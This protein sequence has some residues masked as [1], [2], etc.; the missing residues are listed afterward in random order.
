MRPGQGNPATGGV[1]AL[2]TAGIKHHQAGQLRE[3]EAAYRQVLAAA[4]RQFDATHLLGVV[5]LQSGRL[6]DASRLITDALTLNPASAPAL[7]NLGN[8]FLRQERLDDALDSFRRAVKLQPGF[9]DAH[10]NLGNLLRRRGELNDAAVHLK[11][12][13]AID[14]RSIQAQS[15]FG[16][17]LL[18]LGDGAGAVRAFEA[19]VKIRPDQAGTHADLGAALISAG[20]FPRAIDVL[21]RA[22]KLDPTSPEATTRRGMALA[23][24][25]RF[26][27]AL[28]C[29][30]QIAAQ[31]PESGAAHFNLGALLREMGAYERAIALLRR[32]LKLA[33]DLA[34][35][36]LVLAQTLRDAGHHAEAREQA[37]R[38]RHMS[39]RSA[40]MLILE[41]ALCLDH[42]DHSGAETAFREA[43]VVDPQ[44]ADGHYQMGNVLMFRGRAAE[45]L[46]SYK[47]AKALDP[48][49]VHARWAI[50]MAQIT[51]VPADAEEAACSRAAFSRELQALDNW[52]DERRTADGYK[53][54]GSTQ[55]FYIAY[56]AQD[57][58][59]LLARYGA[60]CAKLMKRWQANH[61]VVKPRRPRAAIAP[62][63]V[64]IAS[65]HLN[66]HSVWHAIVKGWVTNL[67]RRRFEIFL[68]NLDG[69]NDSET[70][71]AMQWARHTE[72]RRRG[73]AQWSQCIADSDL[74]VLIYPAI[75]MDTKTVQLAAQRLAP[76]QGTTWGHPDTSGLPT[77]DFYLSAEGL[78]PAGA[79]AHYTERLVLLPHFGVTYDPA[80]VAAALPDL[81][82]LGLPTDAPLMLCPGMPFKYA[83]EYDSMWVEIARRTG[84]ARLVY[85]RPDNSDLTDRFERRLRKCFE[86]AGIEF[87]R[88]VSFI[89][90]LSRSN[91]YGLMKH[92]YLFLDSPGF[93]GF[94]TVMQA[95]ECG[96]PVVTLEGAFLRGRLG[97]GILRRI[98]LDALV[99]NSSEA[100]VDLVAN[101]IEDEGRRRQANE[102]IV[103]RRQALFG[104]TEPMAALEQFLEDATR[105]SL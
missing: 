92:A 11:R 60:L 81:G 61:L 85:F 12:A 51:P 42:R 46:A 101:L 8:V 57:N 99:V 94:N 90:F 84:S 7:N 65:A 30:E 80:D 75:G 39:M 49:N 73:L 69:K 50:A 35:A 33:P 62:V 3:A 66:D 105:Q 38:M 48:E 56:Q 24:L 54:V 22:L 18:E 93:S 86:A 32:A 27:D 1:S 45:A 104:D 63:R 6:D 102:L 13:V 44:N 17:V 83:P 74:D 28:A 10:L 5:A 43:L 53:A 19:V 52:F 25:G 34:E 37:Q 78:E 59:E 41:G 36:H 23:R 14:P 87:D 29:F 89:P 68:F 97:S 2:L 103:A 4:P 67:D 21:D 64:G 31:E 77:M 26:T 98:G 72:D 100:Y 15:N 16:A 95:M 82:K 20:D 58:R 9:G 96:L 91:F 71:L 47:K 88:H 70:V 55:P 40:P 79:A 76:V